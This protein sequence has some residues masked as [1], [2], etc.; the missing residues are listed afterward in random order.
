IGPRVVGWLTSARIQLRLGLL[1]VAVAAMLLAL[2]FLRPRLFGADYITFRGGIRGRSYD[3]QIMARLSWFISVPGF[4]LML[5]GVAVV[6]L[7]RWGGALWI[8]AAPLLLIFPVY[9][10]K[11]RNSTRLL[12]WPRRYVPTVLPLVLLMIALALG[13][14]VSAV[15]ARRHRILGWL[16]G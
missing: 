4:A 1:V 15:I 13:V 2:G 8:P 16:G 7:R 10:Y 14:A 9:A 5:I 12:W 3:D 11:P 6:S